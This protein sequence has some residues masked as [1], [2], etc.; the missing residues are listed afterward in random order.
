[1]NDLYPVFVASHTRLLNA[2]FSKD[3]EDVYTEDF[4]GNDI[5]Y[6]SESLDKIVTPTDIEKHH[7][8]INKPDDILKNNPDIKCHFKRLPYAEDLSDVAIQEEAA[9][10]YDI[11]K[12]HKAKIEYKDIFLGAELILFPKYLQEI[13]YFL[14]GSYYIY[15][16]NE[17]YLL[18]LP[19]SA[20]LEDKG[21]VNMYNSMIHPYRHNHTYDGVFYFDTNTNELRL[22]HQQK[23][24]KEVDYQAMYPPLY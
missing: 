10:G 12:M 19:E 18:I 23:V 2:I 22:V 13:A 8:Q 5:F 7:L 6:R 24:T 20:I 15:L 1:M 3:E 17:D 14:S 21:I 11:T 9:L 16:L 4:F